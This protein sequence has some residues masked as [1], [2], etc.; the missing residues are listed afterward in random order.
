M[1]E[2]QVTK[3]KPFMRAACERSKGGVGKSLNLFRMKATY[4]VEESKKHDSP[5]SPQRPAGEENNKQRLTNIALPAL[6][7]C[8]GK[9]KCSTIWNVALVN[10]I[11]GFSCCAVL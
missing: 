5:I 4:A 10:G 8:V 3:S 11:T 9:I 1:R 2:T 6:G 7:L